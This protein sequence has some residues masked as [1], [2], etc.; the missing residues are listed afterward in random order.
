MRDEQ[1]AL[2][3]LLRR[4]AVS[5]QGNARFPY[6]NWLCEQLVEADDQSRLETLLGVLDD[7]AAGDDPHPLALRSIQGSAAAA[8]A[9]RDLVGGVRA[10][11]AVDRSAFTDAVCEIVG[12]LEPDEIDALLAALAGQGMVPRLLQATQ[13]PLE[14]AREQLVEANAQAR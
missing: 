14:P 6:W 11:G 2:A 7:V 9:A 8:T 10:S 1:A 3:N 12:E 5:K 4:V 13:A